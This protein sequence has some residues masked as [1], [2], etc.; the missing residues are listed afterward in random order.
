MILWYT[1]VGHSKTYSTPTE[2]RGNTMLIMTVRKF[3][4]WYEIR[5]NGHYMRYLYYSK[6]EAISRFRQQ[7][8]LVGKHITKVEV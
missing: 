4:G 5:C 8:D 3:G 6:R 2:E 7:F 1:L